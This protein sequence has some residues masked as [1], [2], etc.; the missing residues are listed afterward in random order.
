[1]GLLGDEHDH[2]HSVRLVRICEHEPEMTFIRAQIEYV[3][4]PARANE[5]QRKTLLDQI[6]QRLLGLE[7][8]LDLSYLIVAYAS[9]AK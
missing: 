6:G 3:N 7:C 9:G 4:S 8:L 1:M 5:I 2:H